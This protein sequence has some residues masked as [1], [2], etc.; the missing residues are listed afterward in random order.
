MSKKSEAAQEIFSVS[1]S[2]FAQN[3]YTGTSIRQIAAE[4]G[5]S[6]GLTHH[7]FGNKE[8]LG[9]LALVVLSE[10][11]AEAVDARVTFDEDPILNDLILTRCNLR[12][13]L[14]GPYRRFYLD[15]LREDLFFN[16]LLNNE[17]RLLNELQRRYGFESTPDLNLL[18]NKYIPYNVEKTIVLKKEEGLFPTID[19]E[20]IPWHIC[21]ASM[22]KFIPESLLLEKDAISRRISEEVQQ[23]IPSEPSDALIAHCLHRFEDE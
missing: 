1:L 23:Q 20:E 11:V 3:G 17:A 2:L 4:A 12:Y 13:M 9:R 18:Y 15:S 8:R 14:N 10:N 19:Y 5:I 21:S 16:A 22:G 6:V 7:Y